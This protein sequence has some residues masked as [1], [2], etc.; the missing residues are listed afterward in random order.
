MIEQPHEHHEHTEADSGP[1]RDD[2]CNGMCQ[3]PPRISDTSCPVHG[4]H[5]FLG[6]LFGSFGDADRCLDQA[7]AVDV[8]D[9]LL[10]IDH[11]VAMT[12]GELPLLTWTVGKYRNLVGRVDEEDTAKTRAAFTAWAAA[13]G[14]EVERD[15]RYPGDPNRRYLSARTAIDGVTVVVSADIV[16]DDEETTNA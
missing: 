7:G 9:R 15:R 14:A 2:G 4:M 16:V 10:F 12:N 5:A 8:L 3:D 13:L 1:V 6:A 11:R